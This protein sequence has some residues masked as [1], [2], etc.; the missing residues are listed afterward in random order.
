[1]PTWSPWPFKLNPKKAFFFFSFCFPSLTLLEGE[2]KND[3]F[4]WYTLVCI[5]MDGWTPSVTLLTQSFV[6]TSVN[7]IGLDK[8]RRGAN[9]V[10]N[11]Y[12]RT[13]LLSHLKWVLL[14]I[15]S[16]SCIEIPPSLGGKW[17]KSKTGNGRRERCLNSQSVSPYLSLCYTVHLMT[18]E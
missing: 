7:N 6:F 15:C 16:Y 11:K 3:V 14:Y 4:F 8:H 12:N 9:T 5:W 10:S 17:K 18:V 2:R 13:A 1:M